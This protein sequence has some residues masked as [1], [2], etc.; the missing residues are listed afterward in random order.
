[1]Q[2]KRPTPFET[3][4]D[5]Y[6]RICRV[7]NIGGPGDMPKDGLYDKLRLPYGERV[8]G[9]Y[10]YHAA[11]QENVRIDRVVSCPL[12]AGVSTQDVAVLPD[13]RQYGVRQAQEKRDTNPP[14]LL[15][16]LERLEENYDLAGMEEPAP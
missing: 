1:M 9:V 6:L 15:L 13:G 5:G 14:S 3:F 8:V 10:R 2:I 16:S 12:S 11:M 4:G 7:D